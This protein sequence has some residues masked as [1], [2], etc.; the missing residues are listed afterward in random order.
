MTRWW[1]SDGRALIRSAVA[2]ILAAGVL[3][4]P[5]VFA[6]SDLVAQIE[7][8]DDQIQAEPENAEWL[9]RRGDLH[10][11]HEDYAVAARDFE[12]ARALAPDH[13]EID[14]YQGR[15][16]LEA[17]DFEAAARYL[18]RYLGSNPQHPGAWRLR[19]ETA[20]GQGDNC[21]AAEALERAVRFSDAPSP[22]L[23]REWV[24]ALLSAGDRQGA[25][26]SVDAGL[27]RLG[28]EVSLLGLGSDAALADR[29]AGRAQAYL[30][31]LPAGLVGRPPWSE[32]MA[33]AECLAD[34]GEASGNRGPGC[35]AGASARLDAQLQSLL[36]SK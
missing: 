34:E 1:C 21:L 5:E 4:I 3:L 8:L 18:D 31:R 17:G 9:I 36:E 29:D 25:L 32:R 30:K 26:E 33:E 23:Y 28:V 22:A 20:Q 7:R 19:A 11:R 2:V 35:A 6:H 24:L 10:R 12:A 16:G 15:L 14:F 27:E 13:S